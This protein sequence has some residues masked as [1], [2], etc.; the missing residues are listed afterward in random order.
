MSEFLSD[1]SIIEKIIAAHDGDMA[2]LYLYLSSHADASADDAAAALCRTMSQI[3]DAREKLCRIGALPSAVSPVSPVSVAEKPAADRLPEYTREEIVRCTKDDDV[4][5]A[6]IQEA[7]KAFGR[8]ASTSEVQKLVGIYKH[9]AMPAEVIMELINYCSE[10]CRVKFGGMR[11]PTA[12]ALEKEAYTWARLELTTM[13]AAED[14]IETRR[15]LWDKVSE[16]KGVL[17]ITGRQLTAT[18]WNSIE[19]WLSLGF[20]VPAISLAYDRTITRT[21]ELKL[22][23]MN[24][25]FANWHTKSVYTV[26]AIE[27]KEGHASPVQTAAKAQNT[28]SASQEEKMLKFISAIKKGETVHGV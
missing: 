17:G 13:E 5:L 15:K 21:G 14:Y 1:N 16:V 10:L 23:Y 26:E 2:L 19:R 27:Q 3:N 20:D 18:E 6:V 7:S 22:N 4:F 11:T 12:S 28:Q 25:I 9:L 8:P 24:R